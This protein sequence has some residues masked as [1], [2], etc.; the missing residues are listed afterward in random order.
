MIAVSHVPMV[1]PGD[2]LGALLI[3]A[4]ARQSLEPMDSDILVVAQKIVS[5][6][7][8]RYVDLHQV[9]PSCRAL[10]IAC[11]QSRHSLE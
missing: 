2:D 6:A 1:H 8:A 11:L 4:V 5:K 9:T 7:E 3:D 10:E